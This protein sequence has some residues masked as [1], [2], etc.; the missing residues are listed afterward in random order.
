MLNAI[1][2]FSKIEADKL[3]IEHHPFLL[4]AAISSVISLFAPKPM[5]RK[6]S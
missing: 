3:E 6:S 1:L 5:K 4:E 2:D